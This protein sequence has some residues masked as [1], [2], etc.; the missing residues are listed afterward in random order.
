MCTL[1]RLVLHMSDMIHDMARSHQHLEHD[2]VQADSSH[3][4][5]IG[6]TKKQYVYHH[7]L[8]SCCLMVRYMSYNS[9]HN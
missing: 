2:T 6:V 8:D 3:W 4:G 5:C 7:K 1:I 9:N